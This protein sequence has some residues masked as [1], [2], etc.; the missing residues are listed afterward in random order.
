MTIVLF[1]NILC[2]GNFLSVK[3]RKIQHVT[4]YS[5]PYIYQSVTKILDSQMK[6]RL[7]RM[8]PNE[9]TDSNFVN[10]KRPGGPVWM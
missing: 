3:S 8:L 7:H 2:G 1:T 10:S 5:K 6:C 9:P 4:Y